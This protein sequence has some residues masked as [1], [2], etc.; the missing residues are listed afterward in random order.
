MTAVATSFAEIEPQF[1]DYLSEI[2]YASMITVD[3]KGRPRARVLIAVWE[4]VGGRPLGWL[5]TYRTPVKAAH[6][7]A[8]PHTTFSY[9]SPRQNAV[10]IDATAAWVADAAARRRAWELFR[11]GSPRGVGYDPGA[12][13]TGPEDPTYHLLRL[14][15]WRVQVVR[16][17]DLRT[18]LWRAGDG[19]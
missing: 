12:F 15:P 19:G 13:W 3:A 7:A 1:R 8:N 9:W 14:E 17:T 11:T 10:F 6:L 18:T 16:G 2:R 4:V 5:V